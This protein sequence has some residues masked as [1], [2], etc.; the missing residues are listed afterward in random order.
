[1]G[2]ISKNDVKHV[3]KLAKLELSDHEINKFSKQLSEIVTYVK[4]LEKVD[5]SKV[6]PTSQTTGLENISSKG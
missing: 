1:M 5:T 3:A 2:I 6:E 4:E